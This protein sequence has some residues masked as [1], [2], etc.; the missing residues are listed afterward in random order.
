[1]PYDLLPRTYIPDRTPKRWDLVS[2]F[3]VDNSDDSSPDV[4]VTLT[5]DIAHARNTPAY[6]FRVA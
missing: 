2:K 6:Y 3:V 5:E 4:H 1:M